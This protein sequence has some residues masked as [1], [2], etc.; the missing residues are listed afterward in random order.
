MS[1]YGRTKKETNCWSNFVYQKNHLF[2]MYAKY[3]YIFSNSNYIEKGKID[4]EAHLHQKEPT[5]GGLYCKK[6]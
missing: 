6:K 4:T 5:L 1:D 3:I 2:L